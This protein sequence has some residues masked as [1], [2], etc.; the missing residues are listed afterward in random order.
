MLHP[1]T[2]TPSNQYHPTSDRDTSAYISLCS[3]SLTLCFLSFLVIDLLAALNMSN[4]INGVAR[5]NNSGSVI[6]RLRPRSPHLTL[7]REYSQLLRSNLQ[8][9]IGLHLVGHQAQSTNATLLSVSSTSSP[10]LQII[11]STLQN[12]LRVDYQAGV[13]VQGLASFPG[14]NPFSGGE[15]VKLAVS[16]ETYRLAFFVDCQEAVVIPITTGEKINLEM[17]Q[18]VVV[19]L[20]STPGKKHSKFSVSLN[21]ILINLLSIMQFSFH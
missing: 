16:L 4:Q 9:G 20:A 5:I 13:G 6:Y 18:D 21:I 12:T 2:P 8:G 17:P 14:G 10:I 1:D 3:R 19:T 7:P 11:S 15:W